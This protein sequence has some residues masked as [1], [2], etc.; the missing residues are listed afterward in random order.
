MPY[1]A[2]RLVVQTQEDCKIAD[3]ENLKHGGTENT[4]EECEKEARF[5]ISLCLCVYPFLVFL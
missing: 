1:V 2:P 5:A 3:K 4:E